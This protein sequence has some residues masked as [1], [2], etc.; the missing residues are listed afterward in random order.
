VQELIDELQ[1][2]ADDA[3]RS[4]EERRGAAAVVA[5]L[6]DLGVSVASTLISGWAQRH[7]VP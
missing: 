5:G 2:T 6:R 4:P 1:A 7:G 3:S